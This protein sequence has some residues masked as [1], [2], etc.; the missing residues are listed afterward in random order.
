MLITFLLIKRVLMLRDAVLLDLSIEGTLANAKHFRGAATIALRLFQRCFD[1]RA[2]HVGHLG[3]GRDRHDVRWRRLIARLDRRRANRRDRRTAAVAYAD[4]RRLHV[5]NP[6]IAPAT[7]TV[8]TMLL[9]PTLY[10]LFDKWFG[11][12]RTKGDEAVVDPS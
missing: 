12:N 8:L 2:L 3:A 6:P 11:R 10:E 9:L 7:D 5:T 4:R 1:H